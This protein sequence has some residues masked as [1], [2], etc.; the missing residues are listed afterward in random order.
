[1]KDKVLCPMCDGTK[2]VIPF[3]HNIVRTVAGSQKGTLPCLLC[4]SAGTVSVA[5]HSAFI[6]WFGD[7]WIIDVSALQQLQ[8]DINKWINA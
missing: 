6:I 8:R 7:E 3:G 2:Q 4:G 5:Q 1:M